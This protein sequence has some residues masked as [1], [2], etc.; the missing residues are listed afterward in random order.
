MDEVDALGRK[1]AVRVQTRLNHYGGKRKGRVLFLYADRQLVA[2]LTFHIN[3]NQV[4]EI[5]HA[6]ARGSDSK[7]RNQRIGLLVIQLERLAK[8]HRGDSALCKKPVVW[9]PT[10]L[11]QRDI[12]QSLGFIKKHR[13]MPGKQLPVL[14][15]G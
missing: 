5:T 7:T 3:Q 11:S 8:R 15:R 9:A 12:A 13:D 1:T 4:V 2:V 10:D 14:R 6:A